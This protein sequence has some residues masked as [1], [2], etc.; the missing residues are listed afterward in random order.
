MGLAIFKK[1][2]GVKGMERYP[3]RLR[4]PE[5]Q[6]NLSVA[7]LKLAKVIRRHMIETVADR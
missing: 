2:D 6:H 3:G 1:K 4:L 5:D 7:E